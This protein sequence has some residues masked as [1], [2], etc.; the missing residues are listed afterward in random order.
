MG[1]LIFKTQGFSQD[2]PA[3]PPWQ[4]GEPVNIQEQWD[5]E[6]LKDL[7]IPSRLDIVHI[8]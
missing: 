4:S 6:D 3:L 2:Q 8:P 1:W 5:P 7:V